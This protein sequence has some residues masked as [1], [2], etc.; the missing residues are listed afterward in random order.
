MTE[1]VDEKRTGVYYG[2]SSRSLYERSREHLADAEGFQEGS[3][4][5]KHWMQHHAEDDQMPPFTLNIVKSFKYWPYKSAI[6]R[7]SC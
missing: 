2:E 4:I 3:H 1:C 7:I 5:V 6:Q